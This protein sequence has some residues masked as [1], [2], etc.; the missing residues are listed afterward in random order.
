M[1]PVLICILGLIFLSFP[2]SN[3]VSQLTAGGGVDVD[4]IQL[5]VQQD[6]D[7]KVID[8]LR[9]R[10]LFDLVDQYCQQ[11]LDVETSQSGKAVIYIEWIKSLT[12]QAILTPVSERPQAWLR[13]E[14]K[15]KE[16]EQKG[17][18][19][20]RVILVR[21]QYLLSRIAKVRLILQEMESDMAQT[22]AK[23]IALTELRAARKMITSLESDV[24]SAIPLARR[25][26]NDPDRLSVEQLINLQKYIAFQ[27]AIC[28]L[29]RARLFQSDQPE[30][31]RERADALFNFRNSLKQVQQN[32]SPKELLWWQAKVSELEFLMLQQE[33]LELKSKID[34]LQKYRVPQT[35]VQPIL[36]QKLLAASVLGNDAF[37]SKVLAEYQEVQEP[38]PEVELALVE[39]AVQ[40]SN[41]KNN[42]AE[43]DRWLKL[44]TTTTRN[45][46]SRQGAYWGRRA[47]LLLITVVAKKTDTGTRRSDD[48]MTQPGESNANESQMAVLVRLGDQSSRQGRYAD[49][50]K[51]YNQ[52]ISMAQTLNKEQVELQLG[53]KMGQIFEKQGQPTKAGNQLVATARRNPKL[54]LSSSVHLR[55][56]WNLAKALSQSDQD[57]VQ[58]FKTLLEEHINLFR[59]AV[60]VDQAISYLGN[61]LEREGNWE[62]ALDEYLKASSEALSDLSPAIARCSRNQMKQWYQSQSSVRVNVAKWIDKIRAVRIQTANDRSVGRLYLVELELR[63][64]F[65]QQRVDPTALSR[66]DKIRKQD[67]ERFKT[68]MAI[69]L[70][71]QSVSDPVQAASRLNE[72]PTET[73]E[74]FSTCD[75]LLIA[76]LKANNLYTQSERTGILN[77][78]LAMIIRAIESSEP[79]NRIG[80][81]IKQSD[82][83]VELGR[84]REAQ[85]VLK[86][87]EEKLPKNAKIQMQIARVLSDTQDDGQQAQALDRWRRLASRLK[88]NTEN[89]FEA[90]YNVASL[91]FKLNRKSEA[92]KLLKFIQAIPPGW[93]GSKFKSDF[94]ALLRKCE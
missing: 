82:T 37:T 50:L 76:M 38:T 25:R 2:I 73:M 63:M 83:L 43:K 29:N 52:A 55:G 12:T 70:A 26:S 71:I 41:G 86:Q 65:G 66:L 60:T 58:K 6:E 30:E 45:I 87:L 88:P 23:A 74:I 18:A 7:Q 28:N 69:Y 68:A 22:D 47:E 56:C 49:A 79:S 64:L 16:F 5:K 72:L 14:N 36:E 19:Y 33:V 53:I 90:K 89:W 84:N 8:G 57:S 46:E 42:P 62:G 31:K 32:A 61:Q 54:P 78:R 11:R 13:I 3:A 94:E 75:S 40:L 44:A 24:E 35:M 81:Q 21:I 51:A 48:G 77:F 67:T 15:L 9:R 92:C 91:L 10:R 39:L 34:Q 85:N 27:E 17:S 59:N 93:Q 4:P 80:W 20:P 1:K